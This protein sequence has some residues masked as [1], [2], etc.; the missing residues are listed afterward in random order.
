MN[1]SAGQ[2]RIALSASELR[3]ME[4]RQQCRT[5]NPSDPLL[6][7]AAQSDNL[8]IVEQPR[9]WK[10]KIQ[11]SLTLETATQAMLEGWRQTGESF[12]LL[13][14]T[15]QAQGT[16]DA[17][18]VHRFGLRHESGKQLARLEPI[19]LVC[20]H[21]SRDS[22]CGTVGV[23]LAQQLRQLNVGRVWEVSHIG[24]HR[25]APTLW[26][27]PSWRVYGRLPEDRSELEKWAT[28]PLTTKFLRGHAGYSPALQVFEAYL[29]DQENRWPQ[30]LLEGDDGLILVDWG[31]QQ[32]HW[33]VQFR[34]EQHSGFQSCR[35]IPE[36]KGSWTSLAIVKAEK[37]S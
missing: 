3:P 10:A 5:A 22:C 18:V 17:G 8:V 1:R 36:K 31:E 9:P 34:Q 13:A 35:D 20:T 2:H 12:T 16:A 24:G 21:G 11:D 37:I 33:R 29:F 4:T 27:L 7:T 19:W 26:H 15:E 6:G 25:F 28:Q 30:R 32:Q 23:R 14:C